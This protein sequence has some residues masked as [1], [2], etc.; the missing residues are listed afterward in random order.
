MAVL[1]ILVAVAALGGVVAV[2][3]SVVRSVVLPRGVPARL[4][5]LT[6]L[7]VRIGL[8]IRLRLRGR[9]DYR[10][11]DRVLAFEAPLGLFAQLVG[12]ALPIY[13]GFAA[14]FWAVGD[15]HGSAEPVPRALELAGS[16]MLTLGTDGPHGLVAH[17]VAFAAAGV[18]LT[19]LALVITYLP[20]VYS[21]FSRREAAI[22]KLVVRVGSRPTG[23]ALLQRSWLLGRFD[24]LEEVWDGWE[25]WFVEVSESHTTFPQLVFFR[26][27]HPENHW[28]L[29][30]EAVLDGAALLMTACDAPRQSRSELCLDAGVQAL[31]KIADYLR[32][33]HRPP[34]DEVTIVLA[35]EQF[36][37]AL[38][39]LERAGIPVREG[40]DEAWQRFSALRARYESLIAVLGR[41]TDAPRSDWSSWT[42]QTPRHSPPLIRIH[43]HGG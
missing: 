17:L 32:I 31:V 21:A 24:Q 23:P 15:P 4:A 13:V 25:D 39:A 7:L 29:S 27:P 28:V 9:A 37:D 38:R 14:L 33:P 43:N 16:S 34:S 10:T 5:R 36:T 35:R 30:A 1:R 42:D 11:R 12:W 22:A 26:S 3:L 8:L 40:W 41:M 2:L 18:G 6:F 19:L 20:S